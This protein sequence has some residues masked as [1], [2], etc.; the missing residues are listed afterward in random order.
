MYD[1]YFL[2]QSV[3]F[4]NNLLKIFWTNIKNWPE[5]NLFAEKPKRSGV[6]MQK[7]YD[8]FKGK[9]VHFCK[10]K[11]KIFWDGLKYFFPRL[12]NV[13]HSRSISKNITTVVK[14]S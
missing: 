12:K 8:F 6:E 11:K 4:H 3:V 13:H 14:K 1:I 7:N 5:S 10:N 2:N 9:L